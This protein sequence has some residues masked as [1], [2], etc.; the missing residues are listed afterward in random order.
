MAVASGTNADRRARN[1]SHDDP[2]GR[3][4]MATRWN[5]HG[6][7]PLLL[8][9]SVLLVYG[10]TLG[11]QVP[12][13][14]V[15]RFE[16]WEMVVAVGATLV[17]SGL[18]SLAYATESE[19]APERAPRRPAAAAPGPRIAPQAK[20]VP[21][22]GP[23]RTVPEWWEGPTAPDPGRRRAPAPAAGDA[24][25][26]ARALGPPVSTSIPATDTGA[27]SGPEDRA[28]RGHEEIDGALLELESIARDMGEPKAPPQLFVAG[29]A[30]HIDR[31]A[32]CG[33]ALAL[34]APERFCVE[35]GRSLCPDCGH[36]A[37][38]NR[39]GVACQRCRPVRN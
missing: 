3:P 38:G 2:G 4:G 17:G 26:G 31:C 13:P 5:L 6:A 10:V 36:P 18:F 29:R 35:C 33:R 16:I 15:A 23:E 1:D 30:V 11:L 14:T 7:F 39:D 21:P 27:A 22:R 32:D 25:S 34:D 37:R 8:I 12:T 19:D 28:G 24:P 20:T 9:G